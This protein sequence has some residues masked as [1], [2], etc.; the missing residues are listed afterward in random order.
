MPSQY[1]PIKIPNTEMRSLSSTLIDQRFSIYVGLP[2]S[3]SQTDKM[4]PVLYLLDANVTFSFIDLIR[5]FQIQRKVPEAIII[6]IGYPVTNFLET[7]GLRQRDFTPSIDEDTLTSDRAS[8]ETD[9]SIMMA[10]A[11][12]FLH[13]VREELKPFV[14]SNYRAIDDKAAVFG[15]SYAGLFALYVMFTMPDTFRRYLIGSPSIWWDNFN[16]LFL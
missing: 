2:Y 6:G 1:P 14:L 3:Y 5:V 11:E 10:G 9:G 15:T 16:Y 13:F 12:Q 7:D 4:Y 8:S